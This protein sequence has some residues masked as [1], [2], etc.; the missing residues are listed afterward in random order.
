MYHKNKHI[1]TAFKYSKLYRRDSFFVLITNPKKLVVNHHYLQ[2]NLIY[3][4]HHNNIIGDIPS[5]QINS[6]GIRDPLILM[7]SAD[8]I[9]S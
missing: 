8:R 1:W 2:F 9:H 3:H 7:I 5:I 6:M 4:H